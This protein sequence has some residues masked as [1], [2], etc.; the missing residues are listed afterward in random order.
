MR[1]KEKIGEETRG[2]QR[3]RDKRSGGQVIAYGSKKL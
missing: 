1:G 2:E 3:Y